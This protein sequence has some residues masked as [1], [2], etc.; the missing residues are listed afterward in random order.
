[1]PQPQ[2]PQDDALRHESKEEEPFEIELV[3]L[4]SQQVRDHLLM[5]SSSR[6]TMMTM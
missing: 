6:R 2:E 5:T 3:L 4:E 1:V